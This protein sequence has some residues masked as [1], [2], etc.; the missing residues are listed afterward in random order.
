[1]TPA[2]TSERF[3]KTVTFG[4]LVATVVIL[5]FL[6]RPPDFADFDSYV[7][8]TDYLA[9][10][11]QIEWMT[12]EPFSSGLMLLLRRLFGNSYVAVIVAHWI[13]SASFLAFVY[14]MLKERSVSWQGI[15]LSF[16]LLGPLLAFVLVRATPAYI[17]IL[18]AALDST[19][20]RW[21]TFVL[22][23]LAVGFH[24]SAVLAFPP[25]V[26]SFLQSRVALAD[27]VLRSRVVITALVGALLVF[28]VASNTILLIYINDLVSVFS[29][30]IGKYAVYLEGANTVARG[31]IADA[32]SSSHIYYAM[33]AAATCILFISQSDEICVRLRAFMVA[34][35]LTFFA[36]SISPVVAFR[37]SIYWILPLLI[38]FP[39]AKFRFAGFGN[40]AIIGSSA[41]I[42]AVGFRGVLAP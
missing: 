7:I 2:S 31:G 29:S 16:A 12:F 6:I 37:Q 32:T 28:I 42:F 40:A 5:R 3:G 13:L 14:R 38:Y 35:F 19:K 34:S 9:F 30:V 36:L 8:L 23:L 20:G 24:I 15:V 17:L 21:R 11:P 4:A 27:R 39:W 22:A 10:R 33:F 26:V 41:A 25:L 1:M 18:L